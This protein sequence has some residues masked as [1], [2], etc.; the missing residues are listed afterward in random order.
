M[1]NSVILDRGREKLLIYPEL[2]VTDS[3]GN[4][5]LTHSKTPITRWVNVVSDR[6]SDAELVGQ[7]AVKVLKITMRPVEGLDSQ[8]MCYF[9]GEEWDL[10][11][12]PA[13][14]R[15]TKSLTHV[16]FVLRSRNRARPAGGQ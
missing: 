4:S 15:V 12:P 14:D 9:R 10:A 3:R 13:W 7:V 1:R 5:F 8:A 11:K 6:Q 16:A 2:R